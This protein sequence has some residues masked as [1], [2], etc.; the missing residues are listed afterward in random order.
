M[1]DR[2]FTTGGANADLFRD[3][4]Q[5]LGTG[6]SGF[7]FKIDTTNDALR[8]GDFASLNRRN[9]TQ[10]LQTRGDEVKEFL[11]GPDGN[12]GVLKRL[13]GATVAALSNVNAALGRS[14]TFVDTFA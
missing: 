1:Q 13:F 12:G 2:N 7:G 5:S 4:F 3:P 6:N 8:R 10:S 14:G 11:S 9:F